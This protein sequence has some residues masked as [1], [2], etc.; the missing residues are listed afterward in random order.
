MSQRRMGFQARRREHCLASSCMPSKGGRWWRRIP[1]GTGQWDMRLCCRT[2]T[3]RLHDSSLPHTTMSR[4]RYCRGCRRWC[5]LSSTA[6]WCTPG[7]TRRQQLCMRRDTALQGTPPCCTPHT[8]G[9]CCS[10]P[11]HTSSHRSRRCTGCPSLCRQSSTAFWCTAR[12]GGPSWRCTRH[13]TGRSGTLSCCKQ[14]RPHSPCRIPR[15]TPTSKRRCCRGYRRWCRPNSAVASC[16]LR[17]CRRPCPSTRRGTARWGKP[18]CCTPSTSG[19]CGRIPAG[20]S[21][22][23]YCCC[24]AGRPP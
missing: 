23:S 16:T 10:N 6:A 15:R 11:C 1:R 19:R 24:T 8:S 7:T 3:F 4:R 12:T 13:G 17:M 2:Y 14:H 5:R 22:R 9:H 21:M 18:P 20:I